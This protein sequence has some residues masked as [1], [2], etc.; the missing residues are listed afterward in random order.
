MNLPT[1]LSVNRHD[2]I[3]KPINIL[4]FHYCFT[5]FPLISHSFLNSQRGAR[6]HSRNSIM[7]VCYVSPVGL[8]HEKLSHCHL[9]GRVGTG[10]RKEKWHNLKANNLKYKLRMKTT[11]DLHVS[12]IQIGS[13][14]KHNHQQTDVIWSLPF[15][16]QNEQTQRCFS[17]TVLF[18]EFLRKCW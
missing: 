15:K 9:M 13:W 5:T 16:F 8:V 18:K 1:V 12:Y 4:N 10:Q 6:A 14:G 3:Y 17:Q 2:T 11:S 7:K